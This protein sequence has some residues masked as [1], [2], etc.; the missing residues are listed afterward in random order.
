M[1]A[2]VVERI[3]PPTR[4]ALGYA[5]YQLAFAVGFGSGGTLAGF[6]YEADPLLPFLVTVA[7]ALPVAALVAIVI[8]RIAPVAGLPPPR[9]LQG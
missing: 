2:A 1:L 8:V 9:T 5:S 6:L 7:L 4:L 3:L